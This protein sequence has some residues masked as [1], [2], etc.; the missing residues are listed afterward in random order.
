MAPLLSN[1]VT[2]TRTRARIYDQDGLLI[3]DSASLYVSGEVMRASDVAG[4]GPSRRL[5]NG[6]TR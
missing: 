6:G 1:L 5:S 4:Q 2:P 3:L